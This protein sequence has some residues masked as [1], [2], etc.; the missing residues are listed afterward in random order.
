VVGVG[1]TRLNTSDQ[2]LQ[3]MATY[4]GIGKDDGIFGLADVKLATAPVKERGGNNEWEYLEV[5]EEVFCG[6]V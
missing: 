6:G 2:L 1:C 4:K 5:G 3:M